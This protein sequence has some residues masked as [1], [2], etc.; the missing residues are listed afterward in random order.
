[1]KHTCVAAFVLLLGSSPVGA[2]SFVD[3]NNV[4]SIVECLN[5]GPCHSFTYRFIGDTILEGQ[6]YRKLY[7]SYSSDMSEATLA[8]CMREDAEHVVYGYQDTSEFI[9]YDM[10]LAIGDSITVG[11]NHC[12]AGIQY[13]VLSMDTL[14]LLNGEQ[15]RRWQL[16]SDIG[17]SDEWIEGVG[18]I[19]G[20]FSFETTHC[21]VDLFW[22]LNCFTQTDTLKYQAYPSCD[23]NTL[24]IV[25]DLEARVVR[26][27]PN[28]FQDAF[29]VNSE[30]PCPDGR[31]QVC[32]ALGR[33][34]MSASGDLFSGLYLDGSLLL[35]GMYHVHCFCGSEPLMVVR[36]V[37]Q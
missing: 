32:D 14:T 33:C 30:E 4:W 29:R 27:T 26:A 5:L 37:K 11:T 3:T 16:Y 2:Q 19:H 15:R 34:I 18:S 35:Q 17:V 9:Y 1:M 31:I 25:E 28:P 22:S 13:V 24:S 23:Y 21:T 12:P 36:A 8:L 10:D 7:M 6:S 20:P